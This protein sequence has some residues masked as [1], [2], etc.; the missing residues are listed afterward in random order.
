MRTKFYPLILS[1]LLLLL[2]G[3]NLSAQVQTQ[4]SVKD[5]ANLNKLQDTLAAISDS[6]Y[7]AKSDVEKIA[8]NTTFVKKLIAVLKTPF[9]FQHNLE[10]VNNIS[11]QKA[12]NQSFRIITW[13]LP[14][15]DGS[16][17]FYGT[18]QM[19]TKDGTLKLIPLNDD[20]QNI[21]DDNVITNANKWYGARYYDIIPVNFPGKP[22]YYILLGWKGNNDKTT[23]KVIEVLS[24]E[25][26]QPVFG[27]NIFEMA[28]KARIRNRVVF[29][30]N[31][32][33]SMTLIFDKNVNMLIFDHLAPY[34]PNMVGNFEYYASDLSFDGY[35]INYQKFY[36]KENVALKNEISS[37]DE[38]YAPPRKATTLLQ[39]GKH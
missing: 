38:F 25:K 39:K 30:Y 32:K 15:S 13:S 5:L 4:L 1:F 10:A 22:S 19:A 33:N 6:T 21:T 37:M 36:L 35:A 7:T 9:S 14:F 12:P 8:Y 29:E 26:D 18:I 2:V 11:I 17:K 20:T 23:K 24:F 16:Y 34:E 31:K 28:Q 27:K 3:S